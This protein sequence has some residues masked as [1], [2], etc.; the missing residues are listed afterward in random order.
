MGSE[1]RSDERKVFSYSGGTE[2][3]SAQPS[4]KPSLRLT[5]CVELS[6][7]RSVDKNSTMLDFSLSVPRVNIVCAYL[8]KSSG[9]D[10]SGI[11]VLGCRWLCGEEGEVE[12]VR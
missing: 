12:E 6:S 7:E 3:P 9:D 8:S 5:F 4:T 2:Q 10:R 11:S 1:E